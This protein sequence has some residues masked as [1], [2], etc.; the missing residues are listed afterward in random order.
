MASKYEVAGYL[1]ALHTLIEAQFKS[2]HSIPSR[3]LADE[4]EREWTNLK[5]I[6]TQEQENETR[7]RPQSDVSPET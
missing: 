7:N 5:S 2:S 3:V 1:V 4:Y 6:I